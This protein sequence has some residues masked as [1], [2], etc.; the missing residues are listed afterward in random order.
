[1]NRAGAMVRIKWRSKLTGFESEGSWFPDKDRAGLQ[2][3]VDA[4]NRRVSPI[5]H[6]IEFNTNQCHG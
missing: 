6:W 4:V 1:M 5:E 3:W 2:A